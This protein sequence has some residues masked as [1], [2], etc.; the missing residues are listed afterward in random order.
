MDSKLEIW[1]MRRIQAMELVGDATI[2][3]SIRPSVIHLALHIIKAVMMCVVVVLAPTLGRQI[4]CAKCHC[5]PC[6]WFSQ[7]SHS[8]P[9]M[10]RFFCLLEVLQKSVFQIQ[11]QTN[12][13]TVNN[14]LKPR[15]RRYFFRTRVKIP[16]SQNL[17]LGR[18]SSM[19]E[20]SKE[21]RN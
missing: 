3:P 15:Q 19:K 8:C 17:L 7:F 1:I 4:R 13:K 10:P 12:I 21:N 9:D 6:L 5:V 2:Q 14:T 16:F 11:L 18:F 20:R